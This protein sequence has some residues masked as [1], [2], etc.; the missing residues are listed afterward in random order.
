MMDSLALVCYAAGAMAFIRFF[1]LAPRL[2]SE[3]VGPPPTKVQ[4]LFPWLPGQFTQ[5]G[6]RLY[7]HMNGLM[8]A[9]WVFLVL[10]IVLSGL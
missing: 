5:E 9:G 6:V 3:R 8:L 10:G 4:R 7:R 1:V 2:N